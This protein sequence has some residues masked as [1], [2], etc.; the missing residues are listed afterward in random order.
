MSRIKVEGFEQ[1]AQ[2]TER[3]TSTFR[4]IIGA[5]EGRT[6]AV[7]THGGVIGTV[8]RWALGLPRLRPGRFTIDN[9]SLTVFAVRD[10]DVD[11]AHPQAQL[12]ALND[13]CHL[14]ALADA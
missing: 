9:A 7:V 12:I 11:G 14:D 6:V 1:D 13:T 10:L 3:V 4:R 5:H 2:L 8:F